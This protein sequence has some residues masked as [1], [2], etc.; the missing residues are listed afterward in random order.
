LAVILDTSALYA[1]ADR[2]DPSHAVCEVA[3]AAEQEAI[4]VPGQIL[5]EI[6][7][8]TNVRLGATA[9]RAFLRSLAESDWAI[10]PPNRT[11]LARALDL[12]EL[13]ASADLGFADAAT[14]AIA[15]RL[16]V[17][18]IYT[19]DRRDFALVRPAHTRAFELL[20]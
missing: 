9:E 15:E 17:R 10:E 14:V 6:A 18:R 8:L 3:I 11:D 7:Y 4:V 2:R 20:P 1:L 5:C 12:L 19:L 16:D 13:Y